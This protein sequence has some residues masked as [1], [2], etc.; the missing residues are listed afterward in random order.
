MT[1]QLVIIILTGWGWWSSWPWDPASCPWPAAKRFTLDFWID[2]VAPIEE[3]LNETDLRARD[4]ASIFEVQD[5]DIMGNIFY[6]RNIIHITVIPTS[7]PLEST[8]NTEL[9]ID[10]Q[11]TWIHESLGLRP[12]KKCGSYDCR[13][14]YKCYTP[15]SQSLFLALQNSS[16]STSSELRCQ[17]LL[18]NQISHGSAPSLSCRVCSMLLYKIML[19]KLCPEGRL[20]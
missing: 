5:V 8:G 20:L 10:T 9:D 13:I 1:V 14:T 15:V 11:R 6:R 2:L 7:V 18:R 16:P 19:T 3:E 4:R 12:L 17:L